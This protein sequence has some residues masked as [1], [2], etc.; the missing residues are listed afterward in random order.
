MRYASEQAAV[1]L[2]QLS[3]GGGCGCKIAPSKLQEILKGVGLDFGAH[4]AM[5]AC[6]QQPCPR[7]H[8]CRMEGCISEAHH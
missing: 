1:R 3:H 2:T 5:R 6:T 8:A 4:P 7:I